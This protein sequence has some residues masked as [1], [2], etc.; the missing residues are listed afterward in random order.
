MACDLVDR[1]AWAQLSR[2]HAPLTYAPAAG[3]HLPPVIAFGRTL[4]SC[5][6]ICTDILM[7]KSQCSGKVSGASGATGF[8]AVSVQV[9]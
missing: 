4:N 8:G 9:S 3:V 6:A 1:K 2:D 7:S 5:N